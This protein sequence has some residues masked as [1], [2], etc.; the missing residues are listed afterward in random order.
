M[1]EFD[2]TP[3]H[4]SFYVDGMVWYEEKSGSI[5]SS[6]PTLKE[7]VL[8]IV[9]IQDFVNDVVPVTEGYSFIRNMFLQMHMTLIPVRQ[10]HLDTMSTY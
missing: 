4:G 8:G 6:N 1:E 7:A 9:K 5:G 3:V 2:C 10:A